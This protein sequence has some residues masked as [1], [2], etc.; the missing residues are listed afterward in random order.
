MF[1]FFTGPERLGAAL[2]EPLLLLGFCFGACGVGTQT[3]AQT[4]GRGGAEAQIRHAAHFFLGVDLEV[5]VAAWVALLHVVV[6]AGDRK[7]GSG[8]AAGCHAPSCLSYLSS[9]SLL[10]T[11]RLA[12]RSM[13][14][15]LVLVFFQL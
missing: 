14:E 6:A 8:Q 1:S 10:L 3:W 7:G 11:S 4:G 2:S 9:F 12:C 5:A 15:V 13:T